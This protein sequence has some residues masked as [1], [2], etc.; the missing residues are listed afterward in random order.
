[1]RSI[2]FSALAVLLIFLSTY[3]VSAQVTDW[4]KEIVTV[5]FTD[6]DVHTILNSLFR[7]FDL[8]V[9]IPA[10]VGEEKITVYLKYVP[11]E[12]ALKEI[13]DLTDYT[14]IERGNFIRIVPKLDSKVFYLSYAQIG[15]LESQIKSFLS[16]RGKIVRDEKT[17]SLYI[18]DV[19]SVLKKLEDYI[20]KVDIQPK[21]IQIEAKIVEMS[22]KSS[23]ELG[24]KWGAGTGSGSVDTVI[25][26]FPSAAEGDAFKLTFSGYRLKGILDSSI[27]IDAILSTLHSTSD[28]NF[29]STPKIV[30]MEN[31]TARINVVDQVPY[32]EAVVG[33]GFTTISVQFKDVGVMLEVTPSVA[34][35]SE[36]MLQLR[37]EVSTISS[38]TP[39][40]EPTVSSK[41]ASTSVM[42]RD[43]DTLVIAGLLREG[44]TTTIEKVPILGNIPVL[45]YLFRHSLKKKEKNELMIFLTPTILKGE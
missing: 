42:V 26:S 30:V 11:L 22:G 27:N 17:N 10:N 45:K 31:E 43:G 4:G 19:P 25:A 40:G 39:S 38:F 32:T 14:Y 44:E 9:V 15:D 20:G 28:V 35:E 33:Q 13:L 16:P 24:I 36:V 23:K 18:E 37:P 2:R 12:Q 6:T 7:G 29:L 34:G 3:P 41:S 21:Q 5:D 8:N 1:M